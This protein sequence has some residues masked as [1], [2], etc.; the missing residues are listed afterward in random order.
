VFFFVVYALLV[1]LF[2]LLRLSISRG[3]E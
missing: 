3:P 2:C 1:L